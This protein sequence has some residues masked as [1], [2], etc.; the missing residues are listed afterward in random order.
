MKVSVKWLKTMVDVPADLGGFMDRLDLTGTAVEGF[1]TTGQ[2]FEHIVVGHILTREKHPDADKLWVTTVDVGARNLGA[3]GEPEPLQIVCGAQNFVAGDKVPVAMVGAV[4]PDGTRIKKAKMRGVESCGM[5]CSAREL[6]L[7]ADHAGIMVLDVEAPV[8]ADF[9]EFWGAGDTVIDLEITPNR[10]DCMSMLGVAR[11]VGAVYEKPFGLGLEVPPA[12]VGPPVEGLVRVTISDAER[13]PRYTARVIKG[14]RI[15]PSPDWLAERV[16]AAGARSINNI[17]DVTNYILFEL[18]QPLHAFDLDTLAKDAQGRAHIVVRPAVEGERF[19]TLDGMDRCLDSDITCIV[20]GNAAGGAG[21]TVALA[22]V[23]GGLNSEITDATCNILLESATFSSAHTS[24]TSRKLQLFSESSARFER[25]VDEASCDDWSARAAALMA[26]VGGGEVCQ[27][28]VDVYPAPAELP[29]ITLRTW[30]LAQLVGAPIGAAEA[31]AILER[32]GC[33]VCAAA[34]GE[35]TGAASPQPAAAAQAAAAAGEHAAE[36]AESAA[37]TN[38]AAQDALP[39]SGA[40]AAHKQPDLIV[41]PP[42]FRPDLTR[43]I[44]LYEEVLRVWGMHRVEPTLPGGR[45]RA[46]VKP[47]EQQRLELVGRALRA[48]GLNETMTYVFVSPDDGELLQMPFDEQQQSVELI[49]PLNNEQGLMRRTLL[50]GL[51]RSVAYNQKRGV[52]NVQL[53]ETGAVFFAAPGRKLPK[54]RQ[55]LA[56]VMCGSWGQK[57]WNSPAVPLDLFD[58]KGIIENLLRELNVAKVRFKPLDAAQTPWLQP[59]RAAEVLAGSKHLGW[60]GE[61]HPS[62]CAAFD[63]AAPVV[64]FELDLKLLLSAAEHA[65]P[66]KELPLYPA[67]DLDLAIVVDQDIAVEKILQVITSAGGALLDD[68]R[69]FDVYQDEQKLGAG[70]KSVAL[71]LSYRAPDRTLTLEEVEKH[72]QKVVGKL[73]NATGAQPR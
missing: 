65:R 47:V 2:A 40:H 33:T 35:A 62:V 13:C 55:M 46:G 17:V 54:E 25:G 16:T 38:A 23:M 5:N 71:A 63:A 61:V 26:Q 9:G 37:P 18:G 10:P 64:A 19:T 7:G 69:L 45:Q 41:T 34:A 27:G 59:G 57:G 53:Y 67:V 44:D 1:E 73:A 70:K 66:Y 48:G 49:N 51:L 22:G 52:A 32:L 28:V 21:A 39:A 12:P 42:S 68:V 43:E 24:R 15:G 20:D 8:G 29:Q 72:H 36:T 3:N 50:G 30:R 14:V 58:G 6:G 60:L 31:Q 56:A 11:E 4:L